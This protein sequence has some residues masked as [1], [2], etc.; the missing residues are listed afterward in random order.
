MSC[1]RSVWRCGIYS[2]TDR[3]LSQEGT[4]FAVY[5]YRDADGTVVAE[6]VRFLP[7]SFAWRVPD[8]TKPDGFRW[9][10][11]GV[12]LL[13]LYRRPD[14]RDA[15]EVLVVEGEKSVD[16]LRDLGFVA[17]C[18]PSGAASWPARFSDELASLGVSQVVV[19]PDADVPGRRHAERV[20]ESIFVHTQG[21]TMT[22]KVIPLAR[23]A[24]CRRRRGLLDAA[25]R[26]INSGNR[27]VPLRF[28]SQ[29]MPTGNGCVGAGS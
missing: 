22:V 12:S 13:P 24:N 17:T 6:K 16:R 29:G 19:L 15:T 2:P 5:R 18:P 20:A 8:A 4:R 23:T 21:V 3:R 10:L 27:S 26:R 7:K 25:E 1:G 28:G 9:D 11:D 14:L